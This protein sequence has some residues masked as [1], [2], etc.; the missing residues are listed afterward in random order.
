[1]I[2]ALVVQSEILFIGC[3]YACYEGFAFMKIVKTLADSAGCE[4]IN[5]ELREMCRK[6]TEMKRAGG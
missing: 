3:P 2:K 4:R 6:M 5:D 1:M